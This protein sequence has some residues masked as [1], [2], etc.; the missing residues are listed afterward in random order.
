MSDAIFQNYQLSPVSHVW[1]S[2][3]TV[4]KSLSDLSTTSWEGI[5]GEGLGKMNSCQIHLDHIRLICSLLTR[6]SVWSQ[7]E[8]ISLGADYCIAWGLTKALAGITLDQS[9]CFSLTFSLFVTS[10]WA[11]SH[12]CTSTSVALS[13]TSFCCCVSSWPKHKVVLHIT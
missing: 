1:F 4:I 6:S 8:K 13:S 11:A 7:Q 9:V 12:P 10:L 5:W 3:I 2:F